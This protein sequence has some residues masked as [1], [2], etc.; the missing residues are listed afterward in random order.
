LQNN[1]PDQAAREILG[2]FMRNRQAADSLEGIVR[3]RLLD[4]VVHRKIEETRTALEWLVVQGIL[5]ETSLPG[6]ETIFSL[7]PEKQADAEKLLNSLGLPS[8]T[9]G[10]KCR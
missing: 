10:A 3:W 4:E 8:K 7:N 1:G 2:Y 6:A 5:V 9:D